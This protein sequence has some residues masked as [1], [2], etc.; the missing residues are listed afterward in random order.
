MD[1]FIDNVLH[2]PISILIF[3]CL[4]LKTLF[5]LKS[6]FKIVY[7]NM[8]TTYFYMRRF[9]YKI[10][11]FLEIGL[12]NFLEK[13]FIVFGFKKPNYSCNHIYMQYK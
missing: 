7:S 9:L 10:L 3:I 8:F 1:S 13:I 6:I 4:S 5:I 2:T 11:L 12:F